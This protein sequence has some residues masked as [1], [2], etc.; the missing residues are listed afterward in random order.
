MFKKTPD[1]V[2]N[3]FFDKFT[4]EAPTGRTRPFCGSA[5]RPER[6]AFGSLLHRWR[7]KGAPF[8]RN[9]YN[10]NVNDLLKYIAEND[11]IDLSYVQE[12][13]EMNKRK[14]LLEKHPYKIYKG[15]AGKKTYISI[16]LDNG[17]DKRLVQ[18]V[19]GHTQIWLPLYF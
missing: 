17:V 9:V 10:I 13:I 6:I 2:H 5:I 4:S 16:L 19:A 12:Q 15:I 8:I 18:D 3:R 14:E 7:G 11:M 1:F